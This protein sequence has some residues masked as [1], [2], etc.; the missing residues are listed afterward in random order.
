MGGDG[1]DFLTPMIDASD[2][3]CGGAGN[4]TLFGYSDED[5][6]HGYDDVDYDRVLGL[7]AENCHV[8]MLRPLCLQADGGLPPGHRP[9]EDVCLPDCTEEQIEIE[10]EPFAWSA[11][12][13]EAINVILASADFSALLTFFFE[14][15]GDVAASSLLSLRDSP[16]CR[17]SCPTPIS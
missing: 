3:F 13:R 12:S 4:D 8:V 17:P 14:T 16:D 10:I 2:R 7:C 1:D 11:A 9:A 15:F 6:L 5:Y